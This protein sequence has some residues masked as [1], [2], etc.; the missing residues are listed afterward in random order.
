MGLRDIDEGDVLAAVAEFDAIG[1]EAFLHRYG[2]GQA[3]SY[4][5]LLNGREYDSKAIVA[6][7]HGHHPGLSPLRASDFSGGA[8]GAANVLRELGFS[9]PTPKREPDWVRDESIL[10]VD[11]VRQSGWRTARP[12]SREIS[13]L[14]DMLQKMPFHPMNTRGERFRNRAGVAFIAGQ[15][16]AVRRKI[17]G[18]AGKIGQ[19]HIEVTREYEVDE[20][21]MIAV[22]QQIRDTLSDPGLLDEIET[23]TDVDELMDEVPEGRLIAR[24]HFARERNRKRRLEKIVQHR[25]HH[26][27]LDC[28]TCGFDFEQTYGE[29]GEGYIECHHVVPLHES[30]PT[31]TR[32]EDLILLCANC[33]RMIHYRSPWLTPDELRA[34]VVARRG[35]H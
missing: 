12:D 25:T 34:Y 32:L 23:L 17:P 30:G 19:V 11:L 5:L 22:A 7:A 24:T 14:S 27:R 33:H 2:M 35:I 26:G 10:L 6:A 21:R 31:K 4:L 18:A 15:I 9:V 1:R 8:R 20:A 29:H 16:V 13:E 3:K 28:Q